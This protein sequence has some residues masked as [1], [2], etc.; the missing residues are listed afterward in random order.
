MNLVL[1][2]LRRGPP[3]HGGSRRD[4][5]AGLGTSLWETQ[6]SMTGLCREDL[7]GAWE[8]FPDTC[9]FSSR[10]G[11][12]LRAS[13]QKAGLE[14]LVDRQG[15]WQGR[16]W[17]LPQKDFCPNLGVPWLG[18][19]CEPGSFLGTGNGMDA[20]QGR[21]LPSWSLR[22]SGGTKKERVRVQTLR[23][24]RSKDNGA[25]E[26]KRCA[27]VEEAAVYRCSEA[28]PQGPSFRLR[29][30]VTGRSRQRAA[31]GATVSAKTRWWEPAW[32]ARGS[33]SCT[34]RECTHQREPDGLFSWTGR[35]LLCSGHSEK[36]SFLQ[37]SG[38]WL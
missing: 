11:H 29:T 37:S 18:V 10:G 3:G 23:S 15:W 31:S 30:A 35:K 22:L 24:L 17:S 26:R 1:V 4:P 21:A 9:K 34:Q 13:P 28:A 7:R 25:M 27:G 33:H 8:L 14:Q 6:P 5:E 20:G 16:A 32:C 19:C 38:W 2:R 36:V 12:L